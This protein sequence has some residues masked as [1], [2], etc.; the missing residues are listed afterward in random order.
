MVKMCYV[1]LISIGLH[2][3]L[4]FSL[5]QHAMPKTANLQSFP[6]TLITSQESKINQAPNVIKKAPLNNK[7]SKINTTKITQNKTASPTAIYNPAPDYPE[8]AKINSQEGKFMITLTVDFA[9]NVE[10]V[11]I[12]TITGN[13]ELFEAELLKT[14]TTWKFAASTENA[15]FTLPISF[16]LDE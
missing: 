8:F 7:P 11:N 1:F 15:K 16:L 2:S 10:Q 13:Q 9:G 5:Q 3:L 12:E 14:F 4:A 6:V